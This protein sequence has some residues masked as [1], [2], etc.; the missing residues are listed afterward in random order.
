[1]FEHPP[2]SPHAEQARGQMAFGGP[3]SRVLRQIVAPALAGMTLPASTRA[4]SVLTDVPAVAALAAVGY[5]LAA[6][7][8]RPVPSAV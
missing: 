6:L 1:M 4:L 5:A 2:H 8:A 7:P 3:G